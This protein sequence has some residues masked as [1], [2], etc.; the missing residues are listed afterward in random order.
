[1]GETNWKLPVA[2]DHSQLRTMASETLD[3]IDFLLPPTLYGAEPPKCNVHMEIHLH[4]QFKS[5]VMDSIPGTL[6]H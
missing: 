5:V 2:V 3:L 1:M 6:E 4:K